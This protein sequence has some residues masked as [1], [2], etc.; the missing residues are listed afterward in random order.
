VKNLLIEH[1][2]KLYLLL[3]LLIIKQYFEELE[4]L[5][6]HTLLKRIKQ[7][8]SQSFNEGISFDLLIF[9]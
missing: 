8:M 3:C 2:I 1:V 4:H 7:M 5:N 6:L 9:T